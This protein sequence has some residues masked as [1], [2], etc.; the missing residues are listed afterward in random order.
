MKM[1]N[2]RYG[3][4]T[5]SSSTHSI[6]FIEDRDISKSPHA[7]KSVNYGWDFF[8]LQ[9]VEDR[10]SYM[11]VTI[12]EGLRNYLGNAV[13]EILLKS[14]YGDI[15]HSYPN[16]VSVDEIC[17]GCVDHQSQITIPKLHDDTVAI[18]Y[19]YDLINLGQHK[20]L[21]IYGGND[22]DDEP[23]SIVAN[24]ATQLKLPIEAGTNLLGRR[25]LIGNIPVW[26][27]FDKRTG[28]KTRVVFDNKTDYI[29]STYPELV[30]ISITDYCESNCAYCYRGSTTSGKHAPVQDV[31][32]ILYTLYT[33]GV[34]EI[35]FGGGEPT[36]HPKF[37]DILKQCSH[38]NI[39]ANFTT[40]NLE[41]IRNLSWTTFID[42]FGAFAYSIESS[43]H[44]YELSGTLTN[45]N[46]PKAKCNVQLVMG[47]V[48]KDQF[49]EILNACHETKLTL[50]LLGY[51]TTNRGAQYTPKDYSWLVDVIV[52]NVK[53]RKYVRIGIDTVIVQQF[54]EQL[55]KAGI[56][57]LLFTINEGKFS[58]FIDAVAQSISPSSFD[59]K[60]VFFQKVPGKYFTEVMHEAYLQF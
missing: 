3:F 5:N 42:D 36:S 14:M 60:Q 4:A 13:A 46:F 17:N 37:V 19:C 15:Q 22:N 35:A 11:L 8:T 34:F 23:P 58:C 6:C 9:T 25:D 43:K 59:D 49:I 10:V 7:Y 32:S 39:V 29:K 26:T 51:K 47:V 52:E 55:S 31:Y 45:A 56:P 48:T 54:S 18:Q 33:W 27:L 20:N 57:G 2:I 30:D 16:L 50:V 1:S 38:Y 21:V 12:F 41:W 44:I 24:T 53:N 40:R 28:W